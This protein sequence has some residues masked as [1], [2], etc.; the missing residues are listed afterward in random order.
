MITNNPSFYPARV[1]AYVPAMRFAADLQNSGIKRCNFGAPAAASAAAIFSAL[2]IATAGSST[3]MLLTTLDGEWG[4]NLTFVASG[5]ATSTVTVSGRDYLNQ[6]MIETITLN[7][8]TPVVGLKCFKYLDSVAFAATA[9]TTINV[10]TGTSLGLPYKAI[11]VLTEELDN[12]IVGTLGTLTG[13]VLT[14]PQTATTGDPRGRYVPNSTLTGS[15]V[16]TATFMF[17]N[18]VNSNNRGGLHGI[19]HV[20][21]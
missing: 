19:Q 17:D 20:A 5:A 2:S 13:P 8:T 15:A 14:D 11:K 10:G 4:R 12:V 6:R 7:G 18:S 9:A 1:S 21:S 16:L 3:A